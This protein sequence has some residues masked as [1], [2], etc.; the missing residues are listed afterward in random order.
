MVSGFSQI[1]VAS[2][3]GEAVPPERAGRL[4]SKLNQI[5]GL[6]RIAGL[7]GSLGKARFC[8]LCC[9]CKPSFKKAGAHALRRPRLAVRFA[10]TRPRTRAASKHLNAQGSRRI[11][12]RRSRGRSGMLS[13]SVRQ[14]RWG[15]HSASHNCE[16]LRSRDRRQ[17]V[18][19]R[20]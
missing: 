2:R 18:M 10:P 20:H 15:L 4:G 1:N 13:I 11:A 16:H 8:P 12:L 9:H 14:R 6:G 19:E 5:V 3:F 17:M 7:H